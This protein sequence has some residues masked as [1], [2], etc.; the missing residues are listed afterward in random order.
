MEYEDDSFWFPSHTFIFLKICQMIIC[1]V[2]GTYNHVGTF[3]AQQGIKAFKL[4]SRAIFAIA[5]SL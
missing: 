2:R 5:K 4:A 3:F 1:P